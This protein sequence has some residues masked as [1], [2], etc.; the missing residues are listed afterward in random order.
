MIGRRRLIHL[1]MMML[2]F[3]F[4]AGCA[5]P[6]T[7]PTSSSE[8]TMTTNPSS[9]PR[10]TATSTTS[11]TEASLPSFTP[12]PGIVFLPPQLVIEG[13]YSF[14]PIKGYEYGIEGPQVMMSDPYGKL[15]ISIIGIPI[16]ESDLPFESII[17]EFLDEIVRAGDAA[18]TT[19]EGYSY[20][21]N[22]VEGFAEDL[23][24]ELFGKTLEGMAV[25]VKPDYPD[26]FFALG[27]SNT[28]DH[29]NHWHEEGESVF[30]T[31]LETIEFLEGEFG[32]TCQVSNDPTY[33]YTSENAVRVGGGWLDGPARERAY[34]DNL[35]GPNGEPIS[36]EREGS[37]ESEGTILDEYSLT[38]TG[39]D[40]PI[41]IYIDEYSYEELYAPMNLGCRYPFI[42]AP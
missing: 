35:Q 14:Q 9:T 16:S 4:V 22:G 27:V 13:G 31:L 32:E 5:A 26:I 33:A 11:P 24:G 28:A 6:S 8:P 39:L 20:A 36:Y 1:A 12:T 23:T 7:S 38:Y 37:F 40:I 21:L 2:L 41:T 18:F 34:L 10:P 3:T 25:V 15:I 19:G 42:S 29:P 30:V 17:Q